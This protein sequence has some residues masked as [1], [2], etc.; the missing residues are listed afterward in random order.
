M[1]GPIHSKVKVYS[2]LSEH[3]QSYKEDSPHLHSAS[4]NTLLIFF[5]SVERIHSAYRN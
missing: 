2:F 3:I 5:P 4:R 1:N